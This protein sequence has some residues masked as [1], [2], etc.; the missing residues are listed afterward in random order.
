[1]SLLGVPETPTPDQV[2]WGAG[3][4]LGWRCTA[5]W[6][7]TVYRKKKNQLQESCSECGLLVW[8]RDNEYLSRSGLCKAVDLGV[9]IGSEYLS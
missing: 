9:R 6:G 2:R 4:C 3:D 1:M 5:G 8:K 7:A